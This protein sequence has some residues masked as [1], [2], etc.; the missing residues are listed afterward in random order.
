MIEKTMYLDLPALK[1][2]E[3]QNSLGSDP[4]MGRAEPLDRQ[5]EPIIEIHSIEPIINGLQIVMS[6]A[7]IP[8]C[9]NRFW[10]PFAAEEG[11]E[12]HKIFCM[13][14]LSR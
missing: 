6:S 14:N 11:K 12:V 13:K 1:I 2:V 3:P 7:G 10:H 8:Y 4:A 9:D 5:V